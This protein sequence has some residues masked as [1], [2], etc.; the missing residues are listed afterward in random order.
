MSFHIYEKPKVIGY[1]LKRYELFS[2]GMQDDEG[3][4]S[5]GVE[6]DRGNPAISSRASQDLKDIF[7][8]WKT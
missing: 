6:C 4:V 5:E 7:K 1:H 2:S 8:T 3:L